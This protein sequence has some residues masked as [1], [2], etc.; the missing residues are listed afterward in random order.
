[1][2][3]I[4]SK[5]PIMQR[6]SPESKELEER[7][8]IY[9]TRRGDDP[10]SCFRTTNKMQMGCGLLLNNNTYYNFNLAMVEAHY[11]H[12][13]QNHELI[14]TGNL[15]Y[16]ITADG[17]CN[18]ECNSADYGVPLHKMNYNKI[19]SFQK[20]FV[21]ARNCYVIE[22]GIVNTL[23]CG[24]VVPD[25]LRIDDYIHIYEYHLQHHELGHEPKPRMASRE[26]CECDH[27]E[28]KKKRKL[29]I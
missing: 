14:G 12:H 21:P 20:S 16:T 28:E 18:G 23:S 2:A 7:F 11:R 13:N 25:L 6:Y 26:L 24:L 15:Y 22:I 17:R 19:I 3:S 10:N 5:M 8:K 9:D 4:I 27:K 29:I 1:M